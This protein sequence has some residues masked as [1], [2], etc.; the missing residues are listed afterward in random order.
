MPAGTLCV[1]HVTEV[2]IVEIAKKQ[3][4]KNTGR[5]RES[6]G[7]KGQ[8]EKVEENIRLSS[9]EEPRTQ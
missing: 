6:R 8:Q 5:K 3:N 1:V 2:W 4:K 7:E 9:A